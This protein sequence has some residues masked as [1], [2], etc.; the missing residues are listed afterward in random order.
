MD[1]A[2]IAAGDGSRLRS[3]GIDVPKPLVSIDGVSMMRRLIDLLRESDSD[4][5]ITVAVN[6]DTVKWAS[7]HDTDTP[8]ALADTVKTVTTPGS[9][10]TFRS[11][12]PGLANDRDARFCLMTVDTVFRPDEFRSFIDAACNDR[13]ADGYMAVTG[14]IDDEKPL[15][16]STG[17]DGFITGFFD[18]PVPSAC[19]VSGG[20][21]VL[22]AASLEV[23]DDCVN[24]GMT[25]MRD[26]QRA[27]LAAGF[28]LKAR[29][30]SRII[31][32]DHVSD[33]PKAR[34][35]LLSSVERNPI[36]SPSA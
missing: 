12:A 27:L 28:R 14:Y 7:D 13:E 32:V 31:D 26:F 16:I 5:R 24:A 2:I 30:F 22:P 18:T 36:P 6:P 17:A 9:M 3:E 23:L 11:I 35:L 33:I 15:Y 19:H 21:Y 29:E 20:I 25:R 34:A 1:Y 10:L 8:W 4:S